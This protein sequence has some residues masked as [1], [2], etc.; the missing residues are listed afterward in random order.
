MVFPNICTLSGRSRVGI[1]LAVDLPDDFRD[2]V[3]P[4]KP[5]SHEGRFPDARDRSDDDPDELVWWL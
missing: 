5:C 2:K 4:S 3:I 1:L